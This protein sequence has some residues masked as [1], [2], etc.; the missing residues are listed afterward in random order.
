MAAAAPLSSSLRLHKGLGYLSGV[1]GLDQLQ[2]GV[3]AAVEHL[4]RR[5]AVSLLEFLDRLVVQ[6]AGDEVQTL[7]FS[8]LRK[9]LSAVR[10][11]FA[12]HASSISDCRIA[13]V[14]DVS[15][16]WPRRGPGPGS[17]RWTNSEKDAR[18]RASRATT[19]RLDRLLR[20]EL[21]PLGLGETSL[22]FLDR[23]LGDDRAV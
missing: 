5:L 4:E 15:P 2:E 19:W 21:A 6:L 11:G 3:A 8:D 22:F 10:F 18:L 7:E 20:R 16:R 9:E 14:P 1:L 23:D 13:R 12:C 17:P